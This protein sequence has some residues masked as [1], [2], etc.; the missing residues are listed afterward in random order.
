M[1]RPKFAIFRNG[2]WFAYADNLRMAEAA[3]RQ[4]KPNRRKTG[5]PTRYGI[6]GQQSRFKRAV[7]RKP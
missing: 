3:I 4:D 6:R 5:R 7:W 1:T 2:L